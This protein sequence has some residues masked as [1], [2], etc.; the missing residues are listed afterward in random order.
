MLKVQ[1]PNSNGEKR[2]NLPNKTNNVSKP[3]KSAQVRCGKLTQ[4]QK[5]IVRQFDEFLVLLNKYNGL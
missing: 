5:I 3:L 1:R 4:N 2:P